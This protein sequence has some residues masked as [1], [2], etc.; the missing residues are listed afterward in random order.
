MPKKR[1]GEVVYTTNRGIKIHII[2]HYAKKTPEGL[3]EDVYEALRR[4]GVFDGI[5]EE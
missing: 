3:W 5:C 4:M 2:P 1:K